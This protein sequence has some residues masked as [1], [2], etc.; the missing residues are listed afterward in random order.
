[1]RI[2]RVQVPHGAKSEWCGGVSKAEHVGRH[3]EHHGTHGRVTGRNFREK[4]TEQGMKETGE[5][6]DQ[7]RQLSQ[8]E[9]SEPQPHEAGQWQSDGHD[10]ILCCG[11]GAVGYSVEAAREGSEENG[12]KNETQPESVEHFCGKDCPQTAG[13]RQRSFSQ[14]GNRVL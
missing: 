8:A 13:F 6:L 2:K 14:R 11:K 4:E 10:G 7:A 3:V 1:M 9:K 12:Y 5:G